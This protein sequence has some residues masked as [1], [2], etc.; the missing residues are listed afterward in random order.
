MQLLKNIL[1][2]LALYHLSTADDV[3][4]DEQLPTPMPAMRNIATVRDMLT[5]ALKGKTGQTDHAHMARVL[6][7]N[8]GCYCYPQGSKIV[9]SRFN[10]HGPAKDPLDELCR[11]LYFKQKCFSIDAEEGLYKG[12]D[13]VA[14]NKFEWYTDSITGEITCGDENDPTYATRRPCKMDNCRLEREFV[15]GIVN[16]FTDP[17]RDPLNEDLRDMDDDTYKATCSDDGNGALGTA[18]VHDLKC[19]GSGTDRRTYNS[20]IKD[21]CSDGSVAF[22]GSCP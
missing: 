9:T 16:W 22:I 7:K 10:Y 4:Y 15:E 12:K 3:D 20:I 2:S 1:P 11:K 21:C 8:Y 19:C 6:V 13:C 5:Q 18:Q 14:D 17:T